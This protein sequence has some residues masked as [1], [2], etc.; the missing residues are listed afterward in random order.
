MNT[1]WN[2]RQNS[3]GSLLHYL[4]LVPLCIPSTGCKRLILSFD[5][6]KC[7]KTSNSL[8]QEDID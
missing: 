6:T 8:K 7:S 2:M 1:K 3:V 4:S 5:V